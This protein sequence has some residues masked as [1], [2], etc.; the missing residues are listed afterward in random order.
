MP[1]VSD[2]VATLVTAARAAG[3]PI[4]VVPGPSA[5]TAALALAG[6]SGPFSFAGFAPSSGKARKDWVA[7]VG[8]AAN[9]IPVVFFEAPHRIAK[10][11]T[12]L[13]HVLGDRRIYV[14]KE[15]TKIHELL[16]EQPIRQWLEE[17][18]ESASE[19]GEFVVIVQASAAGHD[20]RVVAPDDES[21]LAEMGDMTTNGGMK[22]R[23][24][25]KSLAT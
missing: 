13:A 14:A 5:I 21:L 7:E 12:E 8:H 4:Q 15:L 19:R 2:P 11:L 1:L 9:K 23:A 20:D 22:P 25:A 17:H 3:I 18:S 16:V 10:T 6:I 24:A